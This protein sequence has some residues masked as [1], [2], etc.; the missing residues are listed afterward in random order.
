VISTTFH[1]SLTRR[2]P[3]ITQPVGSISHAYSPWNAERGNVWW[4]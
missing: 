1:A 2:N 4:L 3:R